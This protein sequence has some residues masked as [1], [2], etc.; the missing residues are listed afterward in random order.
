MCF[1]EC[2]TPNKSG[3]VTLSNS[4]KSVSS[5]NWSKITT[6][7]Y[8]FDLFP[9]KSILNVNNNIANSPLEIFEI[10]ETI[11]YWIYQSKKLILTLSSNSKK[12][13]LQNLE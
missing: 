12:D 6:E 1:C 8:P 13:I 3:S 7:T 10:L 11:K 2:V 5:S 4:N 9:E